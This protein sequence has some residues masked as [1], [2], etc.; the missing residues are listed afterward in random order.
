[1]MT[2]VIVIY[3]V[4]FVFLSV[5]ASL[6]TQFLPPLLESQTAAAESDLQGGFGET[7]ITQEEIDFIYFN[8]AMIQAL[9][10]GIVGG[11]LSE[12][13]VTAGFRHA[14]LMAL[15]GWV[16]FRLLVPAAL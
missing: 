13:R 16:I 14:A 1:M 7:K 12:G 2:F 4:F 10:N 6:D 5:L 11:V 15:S 3:V 9:G 8:A